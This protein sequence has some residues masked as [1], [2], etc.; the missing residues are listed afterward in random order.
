MIVRA[1]SGSGGGGATKYASITQNV[2]S[3]T[4]VAISGMSELL[5]VI[6]YISSIGVVFGA[7]KD[8]TDTWIYINADN[9]YKVS[10][11]TGNEVT[12][13]LYAGITRECTIYAVGL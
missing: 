4:P 5:S 7:I 6:V 1:S 3:G 2:N 13:S 8:D 12:L 10:N 9:N 11:V